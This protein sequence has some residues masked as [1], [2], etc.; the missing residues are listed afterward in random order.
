MKKLVLLIGSLGVFA[1]AAQVNPAVNQATTTQQQRETDKVLAPGGAVPALYSEEDADVGPQSVLI[2]K[3]PTLFRISADAQMF[4]TDNMFYQEH[5]KQAAGVAVSTVEAAFTTPPCITPLASYRAE[6][7]YRHQF[8][9]Y[10]G[11]DNIA[12]KSIGPRG[13]RYFDASDFDFD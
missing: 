4:Y 2:K 7:G 1:A 12:L 9:N 8:F 6:V 13:A 11:H 3:K 10:F 5:D